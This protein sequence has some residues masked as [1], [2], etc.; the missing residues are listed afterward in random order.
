MTLGFFGG[1]YREMP[2]YNDAY[3]LIVCFFLKTF[4]QIYQIVF[5][6]Q[7]DYILFSVN[8]LSHKYAFGSMLVLRLGILRQKFV[9]S[10]IN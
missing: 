6:N 3:F 9:K 7:F 8:S 1:V 10:G 2:C 4:L 5:T